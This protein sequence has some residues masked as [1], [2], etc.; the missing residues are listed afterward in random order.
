MDSN[1]FRWNSI[2]RLNFS[3]S[4]LVWEDPQI[5]LGMGGTGSK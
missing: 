1:E 4:G 5:E 2:G 3:F